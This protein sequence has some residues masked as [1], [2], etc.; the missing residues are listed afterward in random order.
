MEIEVLDEHK[1]SDSEFNPNNTKRPTNQFKTVV[2]SYDGESIRVHTNANEI[3]IIFHNQKTTASDQK[4]EVA[5]KLKII[6]ISSE[7]KEMSALEILD[8][9][10]IQ[11][12][13]YDKEDDFS[14]ENN[15]IKKECKLIEIYNDHFIFNDDAELSKRN[16][17]QKL[18]EIQK[19]F[20]VNQIITS[21][22]S[23][24]EL[25]RK[26]FVSQSTL[27]SLKESMSKTKSKFSNKRSNK[28]TYKERIKIADKVNDYC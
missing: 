8:L 6:D 16:I 3:K 5:T 4:D 2:Y 7:T 21:G 27:Y 14:T 22:L 9:V 17:R 13:Q 20:L 19:N 1:R 18:F 10:N 24:S 15:F 28:I 11:I 12:K 25:S 26:Y 23:I